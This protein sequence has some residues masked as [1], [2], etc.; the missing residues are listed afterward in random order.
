MLPRQPLAVFL[1]D[2]PVLVRETNRALPAP[3]VASPRNE[4]V[5]DVQLVPVRSLLRRFRADPNMAEM[6]IIIS[7]A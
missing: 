1:A 6:R 4:T 2:D 5:Q 7:R 3:V